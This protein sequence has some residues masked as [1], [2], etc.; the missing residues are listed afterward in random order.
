MRRVPLQSKIHLRAGV[1][2]IEGE[3]IDISLGGVLVRAPRMLAP[4]T[5]VQLSLQLSP[6]MK[7]I[8]CLGAVARVAAGNRMG[9]H[10]E[11][12]EA[13]ESER[14]EEFLLPLIPEEV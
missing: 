14:L 2:S 4:G 3:T 7:P 6:G 12:L 5:R 11:R 9:I 8:A 13:K 10:M 1:E